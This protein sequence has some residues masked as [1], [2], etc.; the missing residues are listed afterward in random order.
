MM[1]GLAPLTLWIA[2]C[3]SRGGG[4]APIDLAIAPLAGNAPIA[5]TGRE[6]PRERCRLYVTARKIWKS[7]PGCFLDEKV[8]RGP[9]L[10]EFPC[11]GDGPASA[12]FG[13]QHYAGAVTHGT[14]EV[15]LETQLDW[16]DG[17]RW[18]THA[19]LKGPV[20]R[21]GKATEPL[22]WDYVDRVLEGADCSGVCNARTL[23]DVSTS[24]P[25]P[26]G[27]SDED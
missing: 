2:A 7:S 14:V 16:D 15:S 1:R 4:D 9:G 21:D 26:K 8:S 19:T 11:S 20:Q 24:K 22:G 27:E 10:L 13:D 18:G 23:A 5:T 17:C 6:S 12:D 3:A 25:S